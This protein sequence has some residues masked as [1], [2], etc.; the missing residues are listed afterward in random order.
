MAGSVMIA[1]ALRNAGSP[2]KSGDFKL[3]GEDGEDST[4]SVPTVSRGRQA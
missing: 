4:G 2:N 1:G 3:G